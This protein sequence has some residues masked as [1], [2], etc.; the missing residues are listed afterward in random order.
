MDRDMRNAL[1]TEKLDKNNYVSWEYK[2]HQYLLKHEHRSYIDGENEVMLDPSHKDFPAWEQTTS[3]VLYCLPPYV[4]DKM[5]GYILHKR[6]EEIEGG[7]E[8]FEKE[9]RRR[10]HSPQVAAQ[11]RAQQYPSKGYV[12]D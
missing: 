7:L 10:Y 8:K 11:A 9:F 5:Q 12:G 6:C 4:H 2:M 3:R 1:S